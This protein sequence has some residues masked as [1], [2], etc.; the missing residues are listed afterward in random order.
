[1]Y[2][3]KPLHQTFSD[4]CFKSNISVRSSFLLTHH[5]YYLEQTFN[6]RIQKILECILLGEKKKIKEGEMGFRSLYQ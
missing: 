5:H 4:A 3:S 1:M 6:S 2:S